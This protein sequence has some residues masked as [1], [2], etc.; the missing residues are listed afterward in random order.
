MTNVEL[1]LGMSGGSPLLSVDQLAGVLDRSPAGLR[2]TLAGDNELSRKMITAKKK[3]GRRVYYR[4]L[5]VAKFL[6]E[7]GEGP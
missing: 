7:S 3:I 5:D 1:L 4:V 2:L 6:D